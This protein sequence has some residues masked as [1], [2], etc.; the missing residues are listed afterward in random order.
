MKKYMD[1]ERLKDK[2]ISA[3][4]EGE[5]ITITEKIDGANASIRY[6]P[7]TDEVQCFSRRNELS[8]SLTLEG[9]WNYVQ[10]LDKDII[11]C[12]T[13][14]G[15]YIIFGEW[16]VKHSIRYPESKMK[17]FYMFDLYDTETEEYT[18]W[19][20][21]KKVAEFVGLT[22]VPIFYDGK[23]T[24]WDDVYSYLGKS[25]M[26]G[27]PS[28]EGIVVKSQDRLDNKNSRTPCYVKI[29][30]KE[31]SEVH[32]SKPH[33]EI[34]PEKVAQEQEMLE[35]VATVVTPR[36][37]EKTIQKFIEDELIP[38]DWDEHNLADLSKILPKA[39]CQDCVKEEKET[40]IKVEKFGKYCAKLCMQYARDMI[41]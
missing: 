10:T 20:Q 36:R 11:K 19:E 25:E 17:K 40:V 41:K 12:A 34:D 9:F 23:F 38:K 33:K 8:P 16:L 27:E 30:T 32:K 3:F 28:G 6:N 15:R 31:F 21:V 39:V 1:I 2:Y 37:V 13:D 7:E 4:I 22:T 5:H 14:N 18:K 35:L 29:V 26:C 24:T